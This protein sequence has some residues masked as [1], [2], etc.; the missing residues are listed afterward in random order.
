MS[1]VQSGRRHLEFLSRDD[2]SNTAR[3]IFSRCNCGHVHIFSNR[4]TYPDTNCRN[5]R[6]EISCYRGIR[7]L[8][9]N[10]EDIL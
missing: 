2:D 6:S 8:S 5:P 3:V 9:A 10:H 4:D 1:R 7:V